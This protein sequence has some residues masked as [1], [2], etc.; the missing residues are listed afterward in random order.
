MPTSAG[1]GLLLC[2]C[3]VLTNM[4]CIYSFIFLKLPLHSKFMKNQYVFVLFCL[5]DLRTEH[6]ELYRLWSSSN[7]ILWFFFYLNKL[8]FFLHVMFL[9]HKLQN[10]TLIMSQHYINLV[11][12]IVAIVISKNQNHETSQEIF[13]SLAVCAH[14]NR[15]KWSNIWNSLMYF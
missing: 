4:W 14:L 7:V 5:N 9:A 11:Q 3:A 10:V 8:D 1:S 6:N 13:F 12:K 2:S 15:G